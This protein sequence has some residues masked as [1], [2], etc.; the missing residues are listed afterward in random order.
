MKADRY[1]RSAKL[2]SAGVST[3][4]WFLVEGST[5]ERWMFREDVPGYAASH[6]VVTW[7]IAGEFTDLSGSLDYW[8]DLAQ[9][10]LIAYE[11]LRN[12]RVTSLVCL[13][14]N[15]RSFALW[16]SQDRHLRR[17]DDFSKEDLRAYEEHIRDRQLSVSSV[18]SCLLVLSVLWRVRASLGVDLSFYP[19]GMPKELHAAARRIGIADGHT[20][21]IDPDVFFPLLDHA[22]LLV[23]E[24]RSWAMLGKELISIRNHC[25]SHRFKSPGPP[26]REF[27]KRFGVPASEVLRRC[28]ALYGAC[29]VVTFSLIPD[30]KH[31][32]LAIEGERCGENI[33]L[34]GDVIEGRVT[35]TSNGPGG[36]ATVAPMPQ[37]LRSALEMASLLCGTPIES[38]DRLLLRPIELDR[39]LQT[40]HPSRLETSKLYRYLDAAA[41]SAG[42]AMEVRP[43]M[44]RRT[45]AML[46][47]WRYELGDLANLSRMLRHNDLR[48]TIGY[49]QGDDVSKFMSEAKT[50]LARSVMERALVK[51]ERFAGKVGL[52]LGQ[53]ARRLR[54]HLVALEPEQVDDWIETRLQEGRIQIRPGPHGYCVIIGDRGRRAV[55]STDGVNPDYINRIDEHCI[56]CDN[57]LTGRSAKAHWIEC[58]RLHRYVFKSS[59]V[60]AM[61]LAAQRAMYAAQR[62]LKA[63]GSGGADDE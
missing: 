58:E 42:L 20:P 59:R 63:L 5:R 35:K 39:S 53:L 18:T 4:P 29:L 49:T 54:G 27:K 3:L 28:R 61:R 9:R 40:K 14:R 50:S 60:K 48:P 26:S 32:V 37:E 12:Q 8:I 24:G 55:C 13:A 34:G 62:M 33:L 21:S 45:F 47:F 51:G 10:A 36:T 30:R 22:L 23:S 11:R 38:G 31:Q 7:N 41:A 25:K 57:F 44:F 52:L 16:S 15:L 6:Y 46:Y 56:H 2:V 19:Y 43:Q 17:L 1:P